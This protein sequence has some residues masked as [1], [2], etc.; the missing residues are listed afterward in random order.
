MSEQ[1]PPSLLPPSTPVRQKVAK[2]PNG[3]REQIEGVLADIATLDATVSATERDV[4]YVTSG[5]DMETDDDDKEQERPPRESNGEVERERTRLAVEKTLEDALARAHDLMGKLPALAQTTVL[6]RR[7]LLHE[8]SG[9]DELERAS[10]H[11]EQVAV[12]EN[13]AGA[14]LGRV[15]RMLSTLR[16][17]EDDMQRRRN[18]AWAART[19]ETAEQ[20]RDVSMPRPIV[21]KDDFDAALR[22]DAGVVSLLRARIPDVQE[23]QHD[24]ESARSAEQK[25]TAWYIFG[26]GVRIER[27]RALYASRDPLVDV[28]MVSLYDPPS[29]PRGDEEKGEL[30]A[31]PLRT[32]APTAFAGPSFFDAVTRELR[33]RDPN[34]VWDGVSI[35]LSRLSRERKTRSVRFLV[36]THARASD[37]EL[38]ALYLLSAYTHAAVLRSDDIDANG[39]MTLSNG[40]LTTRRE[41]GV[42]AALTRV[43]THKLACPPRST[44]DLIDALE[45]LCER[46]SE[47][48]A[49]ALRASFYSHVAPRGPL[50][51]EHAGGL[52]SLIAMT[53]EECTTVPDLACVAYA[54]FV[55]FHVATTREDSERPTVDR[56]TAA[57]ARSVP[58]GALVRAAV[59]RALDPLGRLRTRGAWVRDV[60][61]F[62]YDVAM[63]IMASKWVPLALELGLL[64]AE[65]LGFDESM[66]PLITRSVHA[67]F[68]VAHGVWTQHLARVLAERLYC[69]RGLRARELATRASGKPRDRATDE[70]RIMVPRDGGR[71]EHLGA[72]RELPCVYSPDDV[73]DEVHNITVP[74][75][76]AARSHPSTATTGAVMLHTNAVHYGVAAALNRDLDEFKLVE[77]LADEC[78]WAERGARERELRRK[79]VAC[80]CG[81]HS[82]ATARAPV[83]SSVCVDNAR[84]PACVLEWS[85]ADSARSAS[86]ER[87]LVVCVLVLDKAL[88]PTTP[89]A[90]PI[91]ANAAVCEEVAKY[92]G[93]AAPRGELR[94][95]HARLRVLSGDAVGR[96]ADAGKVGNVRVVF[97]KASKLRD[98]DG[99]SPLFDLV[100]AI[101]GFDPVAIWDLPVC[102]AFVSCVDAADANVYGLEATEWPEFCG[103]VFSLEFAGAPTSGEVAIDGTERASKFTQIVEFPKMSSGSCRATVF[104][105][106]VGLLSDITTIDTADARLLEEYLGL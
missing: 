90:W 87:E 9:T 22:G 41:M 49:L 95:L 83:I 35:V 76:D 71:S 14:L 26:F 64:R 36:V 96:I 55:V 39:V 80:V 77:T 74:I 101:Q 24:V 66:R 4:R 67:C 79:L 75:S 94:G 85:Y 65:K 5:E 31:A 47:P 19:A 93:A 104:P 40:R 38:L 23:T 98:V 102:T 54:E 13:R 56:T 34:E 8:S 68:K 51:G 18:A 21:A 84:L 61:L 12:A 25:T 37:E 100:D 73:E 44:G 88:M 7:D 6:T 43:R 97:A 15:R 11:I 32:T 27:L 46:R 103:E 62:N 57:T 69:A 16:V 48:G 29:A 2:R 86:A 53:D 3:V 106:S 89:R 52:V 63:R 70:P 1:P 10:Q 78:T 82:E 33:A 60:P 92:Y 45:L 91:C 59:D 28:R 72:L 42:S 99:E 81:G 20:T 17:S 30:G 50:W 105:S 58:L